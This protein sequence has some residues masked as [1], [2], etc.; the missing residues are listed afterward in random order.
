[1]YNL[2]QFQVEEKVQDRFSLVKFQWIEKGEGEEM[3]DVI[4]ILY[5]KYR[6]HDSLRLIW[7]IYV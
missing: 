1:M 6:C 3:M 5:L 4:Y 7:F 2:R